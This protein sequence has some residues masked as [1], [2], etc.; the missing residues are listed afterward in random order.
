MV[1]IGGYPLL[2]GATAVVAILGSA[3]VWKIRSVA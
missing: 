1:V 2:F 3:F